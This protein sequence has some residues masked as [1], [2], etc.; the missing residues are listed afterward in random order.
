ME[1]SP[2]RIHFNRDV[3][4]SPDRLPPWCHHL[5]GSMR[6]NGVMT[7]QDP[8]PPW[9]HHLPGPTMTIAS[10]SP[11]IH[12]TQI[13]HHLL[14]STSTMYHHLPGSII[15]RAKYY[16]G[17]ISVV[18]WGPMAPIIVPVRGTSTTTHHFPIPSKTE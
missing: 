12:D 5:P 9:C 13:C 8:L 7:P 16:N 15:L 3:I 1:S 18:F 17:C 10:S 2:P 14:G 4:T 11:R 6:A